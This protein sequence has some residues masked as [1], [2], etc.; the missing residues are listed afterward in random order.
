MCWKVYQGY[1]SYIYF[2]MAISSF[3]IICRTKVGEAFT[4]VVIFTNGVLANE[5]CYQELFGFGHTDGLPLHQD[6]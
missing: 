1:I 4:T 3:I 2:I 6:N 5:E